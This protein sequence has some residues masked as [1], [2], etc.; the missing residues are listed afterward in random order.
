M[1]TKHFPNGFTSWQETHFE[2]VQAITIRLVN[3]TIDE[4]SQLAFI[5]NIQGTG[6]LYEIAED[7][8]DEFEKTNRD[9]EWDGDFFDE[10]EAFINLKIK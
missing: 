9:K 6:G 5:Y 2:I 1:E 8:T 10:I 4:N 3:N 7:W